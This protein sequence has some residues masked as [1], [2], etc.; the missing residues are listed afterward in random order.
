MSYIRGQERMVIQTTIDYVTASLTTL[1][2]F[3]TAGSLP[4]GAQY[5]VQIVDDLP[6]LEKAIAPNTVSIVEGKTLDDEPG[7]LGASGGGLHLTKQV[8]F[9]DVFGENIG[10]AKAIAADVRAILTGKLD[11]PVTSRF[12]VLKDYSVNPAVG[13]TALIEYQDIEMDRPLNQEFQKT[14]MTLHVTAELQW[15]GHEHS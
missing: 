9:V 2:W 15:T 7:E 1:G 12:Q 14:W 5:P 8:I 4:Y 10:M 6:D 3:L 11:S 13:T